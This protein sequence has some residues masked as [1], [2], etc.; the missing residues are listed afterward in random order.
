MCGSSDI[1]FKGEHVYL[2]LGY[3]T[4]RI[5]I[6]G[7]GYDASPEGFPQELGPNARQ[8]VANRLAQ[9]SKDDLIEMLLQLVEAGE[10]K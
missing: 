3:F 8:A 1:D 6:D 4:G 7:A 2:Y 10:E 9:F 5:V